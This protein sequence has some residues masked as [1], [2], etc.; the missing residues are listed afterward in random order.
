MVVKAFTSKLATSKLTVS[1]LLAASGW[2]ALGA[3]ALPTPVRL[4]VTLAYLLVWRH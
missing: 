1:L 3:L 2:V 4:P